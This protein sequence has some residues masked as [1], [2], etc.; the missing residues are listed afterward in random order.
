[1]IP[2]ITKNND[3]K[4]R[5]ISRP[6]AV[7][8]NVYKVEYFIY[9]KEDIKITP[10]LNR[11]GDTIIAVLPSEQLMMFTDGILMRR[12]YYREPDT[13]YPDDTYDLQIVD[14]MQIWLCNNNTI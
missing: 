1:M 7:I 5:I 13:L 4:D 8:D 2:R 3:L 10:T 11:E 14:N 12:A 6:E 9:G